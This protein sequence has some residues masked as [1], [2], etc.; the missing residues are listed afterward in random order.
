MQN[1]FFTNADK[2]TLRNKIN[3]ILKTD[4]NIQHLDFLIGYIRLSGLKSIVDSM[5]K[6]NSRI[7]VGLKSDDKIYKKGVKAYIHKFKFKL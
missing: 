6:F 2:D 1:S 4:K 3:N 7:L 5:S